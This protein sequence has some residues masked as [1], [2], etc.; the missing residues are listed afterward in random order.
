MISKSPRLCVPASQRVCQLF[1]LSRS[2]SFPKRN[3]ILCSDKIKHPSRNNRLS[4][5]I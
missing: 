2:G 5:K 3:S 1:S 4:D